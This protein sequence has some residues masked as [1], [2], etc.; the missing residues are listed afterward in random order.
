[1][2]SFVPPPRLSL[3][4]GTFVGLVSRCRFFISK[5]LDGRSHLML[6]YPA[7]LRMYLLHFLVMSTISSCDAEDPVVSTL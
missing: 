1:M 7:V 4:D 5:S 6:F 3:P 2:L